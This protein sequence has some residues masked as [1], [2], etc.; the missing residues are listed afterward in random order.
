MGHRLTKEKPQH[1]LNPHSIRNT[2][3]PQPREIEND[4]ISPENPQ[5][6][7]RQV[8][9]LSLTTPSKENQQFVWVRS[10]SV[11]EDDRVF[12]VSP[13]DCTISVFSQ[14]GTF[15]Y[16][17]KEGV[18]SPWKVC[19]CG[20]AVFVTD[21]CA[22]SKFTLSGEYITRWRKGSQVRRNSAFYGLD[23]D[24]ASR[25]YAIDSD[26]FLFIFTFDCDLITYFKIPYLKSPCDLAVS[27]RG[28]LVLTDM[29]KS[30]FIFWG[31][32]DLF[33]F[34]SP[35][36]LQLRDRAPT[37]TFCCFDSQH[38]ILVT[39]PYSNCIRLYSPSFVLLH[40]L[41]ENNLTPT[42]KRPYGIAV[43]KAGLVLC[44]CDS[45]PYFFIF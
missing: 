13:F 45:D 42:F 43:N 31:T 40:T 34:R 5:Y 21:S 7:L 33:P 44:P 39:D 11:A 20:D 18:V 6:D 27:G 9:C 32:E 4:S 1:V 15:L 29:F 30:S 25:I 19:V 10:I 8:P 16:N 41:N 14:D 37:A 2:S 38:N 28:D 23:C 17:F 12:A 24:K 3:F 26:C 35:F 22:V 36:G